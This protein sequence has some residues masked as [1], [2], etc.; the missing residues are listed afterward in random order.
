MTAWRL[1]KKEGLQGSGEIQ[2]FV[3]L[4]ALHEPF[5]AP[6]KSPQLLSHH[7]FKFL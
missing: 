1:Q 6:P 2:Q 4:L 5:H 3:N 7:L